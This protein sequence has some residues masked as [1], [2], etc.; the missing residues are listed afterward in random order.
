M[1][2]IQTIRR[3]HGFDSDMRPRVAGDPVAILQGKLGRAC[4]R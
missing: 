4:E 2:L 1:N 3:G